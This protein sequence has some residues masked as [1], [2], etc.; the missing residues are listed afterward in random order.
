MEGCLG[1]R[2][3]T[4]V[5][6]GGWGWA[7]ALCFFVVEVCTYGTLKSLGV[8]LQD[9]MLEFEE[10]S[11][12]V[13]FAV[14]ICI[15]MFSFTAPLST[16]LSTRLGHRPVVMMGGFLMSLGTITSGFINS[17]H[18]MYITIGVITGLGYSLAFLPTVTLLAQYFS[19]R[20]AL[21]TSLASS[22]ES[23]A[24]FAFAPA[25]TV[26][27]E[28]IGWRYCL[29]LIGA[30]QTCVI[31]CGLLL[32]PISIEPEPG[33]EEP[34]CEKELEVLF[35]LENEQTRTSIS[36]TASRS[37]EDSGV[38]SLSSSQEEVKEQGRAEPEE[39]N[40][41]E[42]TPKLLDFTV[43]KDGAF[44]CYSLFGLFATAGFFAPQ[45]YVIELSKSRGV[46]PH[47][48]SY[49]LSVMAVAEIVGRLT[50]G[51]ILTRAPI[52]KTLV[53]LVCVFA[54][55]LVLGAFTLASGFWMLVF[56]CA[57]YGY[58]MGTVGSTHIPLLAE[59]DVVGV[60]RMASAVGVYVCIQSFAGL[61]G[62]PLGGLL[63]DVTQNYGA[64]FA[65]CAGGMALSAVCLALVRPIK[66]CRCSEEPEEPEER[67]S[68][69]LDFLDVDLPL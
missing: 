6:E 22:G 54:M 32:C 64:A 51:L 36:S 17:I 55:C 19:R 29:V 27:K 69:K 21:V 50:I 62:P 8:F 1:P 5:P 46:E 11:S 16:L 57:I 4:A 10:S 30:I 34:L 58:F 28:H 63:V 52:R 18:D 40:E 3:Y 53:L 68:E 67:D 38:T 56:C 43:L 60:Q 59:E 33:K 24:V 48:A 65:L 35:E 23:F 12:R 37:S 45:L 26:L 42:A 14:S 25:F 9:L 39:Q 2:V 15:F 49:M 47:M 66:S 7:V 20:R 44:I 61:A 13:S 31:G 41:A